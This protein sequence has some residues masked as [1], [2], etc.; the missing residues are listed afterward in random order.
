MMDIRDFYHNKKVFLTGHTGFKGSWMTLM[1]HEL[2]AI[3]AG[4]ALSP[5]NSNDLFVQA[6]VG[7]FLIDIRGDIL[8]K[9]LLYDG[10]NNFQPDIVFHFAAQA[11]VSESYKNPLDTWNVNLMGTLNLLEVIRS[12]K[13][14]KSVVI[15]TTDKVYHNQDKDLG[16]VE[17]D[18]LG[19]HDPYSASKASVEILVDS[20]RK[21]FLSDI[22]SPINISTVRAGNVLG[23]GDWSENRL[24]PDFY[25]ALYSNRIF[26]LRNPES[27]RP[28]QH[29]LDVN[30]AYLLIAK[31]IFF[32]SD[33]SLHSLNISDSNIETFT[34][35]Q[36]IDYLNRDNIV[37]VSSSQN[38]IFK[39]TKI[40]KLNS[41]KIFELL[42]WKN[43]LAL[44]ECLSLVVE[45]YE[46]TSILSPRDIVTNQIRQYF[47][48]F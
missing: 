8:N 10:V 32:N 36:I 19:G 35:K 11:L 16:Y 12:S 37:K 28:W 44:E 34:T 30:F 31:N 3:V 17:T 15:I 21:S 33:S 23:G 25:R 2:G 1:L 43:R 45:Y 26:N 20:Y 7:N 42:A 9:D 48:K 13:S 41:L 18:P 38:T 39:E 4:Y 6:E 46:N 14:I 29:V 5:L 47:R 24:I 22:K 27:I 40:L